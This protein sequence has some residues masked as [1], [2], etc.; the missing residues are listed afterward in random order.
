[1]SD[2]PTN[3]ERQPMDPSRGISIDEFLRQLADAKRLISPLP[4]G[5]RPGQTCLY[6][7]GEVFYVDP[8]AID[9]LEGRFHTE[10]ALAPAQKVNEVNHDLA[11]AV[12]ACLKKRPSPFRFDAC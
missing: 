12:F 11:A 10:Y 3:A 5:P 2:D 8:A 9:R 6:K 4:R 7:G 1:M